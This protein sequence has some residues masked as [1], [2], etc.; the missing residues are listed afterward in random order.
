[1]TKTV[2][3]V[4]ASRGLGLELVREYLRRDYA[5]VATE[6]NR[7]EALHALGAGSPGRL[8]VERLDV[9]DDAAIEALLQ[10]LDGLRLD[11]LFVNAGVG[12]PTDLL[13]VGSDVDVGVLHANA[14]GPARLA[15]LFLPRVKPRSGVIAF[16]SST[17][18]S[19][20][21]D[22]SGGWDTYRA[23]KAAQNAYARALAVR[24]A[25]PLGVTVLSINPGWVKTDLG[26][27]RAPLQPE[28][29]I[30]AVVDLVEARAGSGEH[31][32][33]DHTGDQVPW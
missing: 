13:E 23:S 32:F 15:R 12:S 17:M 16:M 19:I 18:G 11:V 27:P 4:G 24:H 8:R 31:E 6:R 26:G 2:L 29:S 25:R 10:T 21:D 20:E 28:D 5:V 1:M 33:L 22:T 14:V 30:P 3:I 7:S 9:T